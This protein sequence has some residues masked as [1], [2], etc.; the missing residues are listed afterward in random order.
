MAQYNKICVGC[1]YY[2]KILTPENYNKPYCLLN[3]EVV[4][5]PGRGCDEK[6]HKEGK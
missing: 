1:W 5:F 6:M 2:T 3:S 4:K